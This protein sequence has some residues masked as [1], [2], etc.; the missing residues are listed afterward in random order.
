M[1]WATL[2][3]VIWRRHLPIWMTTGMSLP[4]GTFSSLNE[5]EGSVMTLTRGSPETFPQRSQ[6]APVTMGATGAFGT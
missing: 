3:M 2:G 4:T 6:E 1:H 5:P